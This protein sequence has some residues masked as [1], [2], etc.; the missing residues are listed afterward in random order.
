MEKTFTINGKF[1]RSDLVTRA[2]IDRV[3]QNRRN[4]VKTWSDIYQEVRRQWIEA[5]QG[6]TGR[7]RYDR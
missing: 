2:S 7:Y 4:H 6:R 5:E 1:I 3:M